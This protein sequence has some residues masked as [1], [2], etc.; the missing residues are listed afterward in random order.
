[1]TKRA[2]AQVL[3]GD[4]EVG[5][6]TNQSGRVSF[7]YTDR[8]SDRP[9]LGLRF[10]Y[11]PLARRKGLGG[12]VPTWF[13]NLLPEKESGLRRMIMAE[14]GVKRISDFTLLCHLGEDL[15]G[16]VRVRSDGARLD[17]TTMDETMVLPVPGKLS[18]SLSGMQVKLSMARNGEDFVYQGV[19]GDWIV[20]FPSSGLA[21]L[22]ENENAIM[23]WL[24]LAGIDVPEHRLVTPADLKNLPGALIAPGEHAFAIKRFDREAGARI[25]QEDFAQ[26]FDLLPHEKE[27][28]KAEDI[29]LLI[30]REC[31]QDLTEYVRRVAACVV[32][33]NTDEHMK[34][35]SLRYPDGRT[36]RLSPAYDIVCVTAYERFRS[37]TL[38][39]PLN[40]QTDTRHVTLDHFRGFA[41]AAGANPEAVA[42]A[43]RASVAALAE[44]WPEVLANCPVPDFVASHIKS[45]LRTLPLLRQA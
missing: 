27:R 6:L 31:P 33:G 11:E 21:S 39:L 34:N 22:P 5:L 29:A 32:V 23:T 38:T 19:G 45:R 26:I 2:T 15:P 13:S 17:E 41:D 25:H 30:Q 7:A 40:G 42:D 28:G 10:E 14:L 20:K 8:S 43:A 37:D 44:T 18:F 3:L 35:W 24:S 4:R 36:R 1:M 9:V 16:A 12:G